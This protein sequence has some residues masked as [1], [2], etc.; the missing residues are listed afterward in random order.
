[1]NGTMTLEIA[2]LV[3][4]AEVLGGQVHLAKACGYT[5]RRN[6]WPWFQEGGRRVPEEVCPL[7]ERATRERGQ[8]VLC[9]TLRSDVR[10]VRVPDP[11]W[12][13]GRPLVDVTRRP[14]PAEPAQ[15]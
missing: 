9:E 1:M 8:P 12:P 3:R 11:A 6:V 5:D 7:I 13:N 15:G 10:W 14:T 4:A 2:A